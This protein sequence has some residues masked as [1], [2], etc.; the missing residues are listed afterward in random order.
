MPAPQ[1]GYKTIAHHDVQYRWIMQNVSGSNELRVHA[2]AP[3]NGQELRALLPKVVSWT[4]VTDAIDFGN[5]NGWLPNEQA[6]P[7]RCRY[8]K[9]GFVREDGEAPEEKKSYRR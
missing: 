1:K 8:T 3:V 4:M 9:R 5:S 6:P 7:Y 2:S